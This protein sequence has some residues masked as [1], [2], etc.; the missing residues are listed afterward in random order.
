MAKK[1]KK[2]MKRAV[3]GAEDSLSSKPVVEILQCANDHLRWLSWFGGN[4]NPNMAITLAHDPNQ[5]EPPEPGSCGLELAEL[6]VGDL[7]GLVD[8]VQREVAH[9]VSRLVGTAAGPHGGPGHARPRLSRRP[10]RRRARR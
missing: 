8:T 2:S 6:S 9:V 7:V 1:A 3:G 10:A 4:F 5:G